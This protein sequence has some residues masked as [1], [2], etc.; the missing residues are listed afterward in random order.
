MSS[1]EITFVF[2]KDAHLVHPDS[3]RDELRCWTL[4][5]SRFDLHS[6]PD[7]RMVG[8]LITMLSERKVMNATCIST[9]GSEVRCEWYFTLFIVV[10][11][12]GCGE[13]TERIFIV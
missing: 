11:L 4:Q 5:G 7:Y 13:C 2:Q 3:L 12:Q 6:S 8:R 9:R 10:P 1:L